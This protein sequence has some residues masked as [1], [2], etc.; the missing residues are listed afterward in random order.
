MIASIRAEL[1]KATTT[2]LWWILLILMIGTIAFFAGTFALALTFGDTGTGPDGQALTI[3]PKDMA[4][5]VYTLGVSLGYAFP[6]AFGAILMTG[7]FRH[8]TLATTLLAQPSRGRLVLG[9]LAAA[10]PFAGL[11]GAASA[12]TAVAVGAAALGLAGEPTML[13]DADVLRSIGLSIVAM[14]AWMLVGVGFGSVIT[15]QVAA[16]VTVLGWTQLVEPILRLA[17]GFWEPAAPIARFLPG[18]AGEAL[19]GGSFYSTTGLSD[20]LPAWAGLLVLLGYGAVA[21]GIGWLTTLRR[22]VT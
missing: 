4:I 16:I 22:D 6:L 18:A 3:A 11:Y 1:R 19:A 21:A 7:E 2:R 9:K 17:L 5:T 13:D 15:N 20:L 14:A 10:L 8:R 12:A